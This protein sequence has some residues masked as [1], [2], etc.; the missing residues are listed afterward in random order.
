MIYDPK[1]VSSF[2][3]EA[4]D[5]NWD[6]LH[7]DT[8]PWFYTTQSIIGGDDNVVGIWEQQGVRYVSFRGSVSAENWLHNAQFTPTDLGN[9]VQVHSGTWKQWQAM[10]GPIM[11]RLNQ[12]FDG[13]TVF[14]GHS[15]GGMLA[16]VASFD[17][18]LQNASVISYGSPPVFNQ[19]GADML[20][21]S[22]QFDLRFENRDDI[23]PALLSSTYSK[24]GQTIQLQSP[25]HGVEALQHQVP[26]TQKGISALSSAAG[27]DSAFGRFTAVGAIAMQHANWKL[28]R[29][30]P[31][32]YVSLYDYYSA[33]PYTKAAIMEQAV[34]NYSLRLIDEA[35]KQYEGEVAVVGSAVA[36]Q[37]L[38]NSQLKTI[39]NARRITRAAAAAAGISPGVLAAEDIVANGAAKI[40]QKFTQA[41]EL[42]QPILYA[43]AIEQFV[44]A[45]LELDNMAAAN[46]MV[47]RAI[48]KQQ[49]SEDFQNLVS[50]ISDEIATTDGMGTLLQLATADPSS[51]VLYDS[52]NPANVFFG[53]ILDEGYADWALTVQ[54]DE[55]TGSPSSQMGVIYDQMFSGEP[56]PTIEQESPPYAESFAHEDS[57]RDRH[58]LE[59]DLALASACN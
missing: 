23:V 42:V 35:R 40:A 12:A 1:W 33:G 9:G 11:E 58:E 52:E 20:N 5:E 44:E 41:G 45:G 2:G 46:D 10:K 7:P 54:G 51:Q 8:E 3:R 30:D 59:E 38:I 29:H 26:I 6:S 50:V 55:L 43:Q 56:L 27:G 36:L 4:T 49:N 39:Q 34:D 32:R 31:N 14:T 37:K 22:T 13:P 48:A 19:A 53:S 57:I 25:L 21:S 16:H 47:K 18:G 24:S 15:L 28:Q 17:A